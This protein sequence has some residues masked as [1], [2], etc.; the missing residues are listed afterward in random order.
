MNIV[1]V[2]DLYF[3]YKYNFRY[4]L[5]NKFNNIKNIYNIFYINKAL[6]YFIFNKLEDIDKVELYNSIY[7]FKFFLGQNS[8]FNKTNKFF[9]LGIWYFNINIQILINNKKEIFLLLYFF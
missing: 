9:S 1:I 8:F 6:F 4:I 5:I 7:L 3:S 2:N